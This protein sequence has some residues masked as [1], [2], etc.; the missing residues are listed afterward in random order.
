[1]Q[2]RFIFR[3]IDRRDLKNFLADGEVRSKNHHAAQKC[4]QTNYE[5][6]IE[7]RSTNAFQLP[8]GGVVNDYVAFYFSP[9]TSFT[10]A[11]H[12]GQKV[13]VTSP[14][15]SDLGRSSLEDRLFLVAK[16]Q[17]IAE[18]GAYYCFSNLALNSHNN[19]AIISNDISLLPQIVNWAAFDEQPKVAGI[20]EI[21][22]SGVCK[23][24]QETVGREHRRQARMAE[25]LVKSSVPFG[26][27]SAIIAPNVG[28]F[29]CAQELA[30]FY[31]FKGLVLHNS[32]CF[33]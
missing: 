9:V 33:R 3:Q 18:S 7:L 21:G 23:Y 32:D 4:H 20:T 31:N 6:L 13:N 30:L 10:Y 1:M 17:D 2:D 27:F 11:I 5:N 28:S 8:Y 12:Q 16:V 25:F 14:D 19:Q 26:L 15:G 29:N 24:F 22:Y